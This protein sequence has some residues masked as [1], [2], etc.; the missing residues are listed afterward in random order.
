M[1]A[2]LLYKW[3]TVENSRK[4]DEVDILKVGHH[5]SRTSTTK[6]FLNQIK[7]KVALISVGKDNSY[8]HP[9]ENTLKRLNDIGAKIFRTDENGTI[10]I[11]ET[12]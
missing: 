8:G 11:V 3:N 5:G 7:P 10:L 6:S 1:S 4:W 2:Q 9:T 12:K